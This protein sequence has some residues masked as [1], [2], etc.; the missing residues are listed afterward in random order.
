MQQGEQCVVSGGGM[1]SLMPAA[2]GPVYNKGGHISVLPFEK[3]PFPLTFASENSPV[4]D[5]G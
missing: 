5:F 4:F 1:G 3:H 2:L